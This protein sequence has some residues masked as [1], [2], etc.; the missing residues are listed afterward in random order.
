M[1]KFTSSPVAFDALATLANGQ[2][3]DPFAVLG[4]HPDGRGRTLVRAFHPAARSIDLRLIAT[5]EILPMTK[6]SPAGLF[7]VV[8]EAREPGEPGEP[9]EFCERHESR[10]PQEL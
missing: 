9:R 8:V 3:R 10:E 2:N 6:L 1:T 5:G 4:P 7:E